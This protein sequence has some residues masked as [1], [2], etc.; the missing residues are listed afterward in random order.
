M[1]YYE[2]S[3]SHSNS[4]QVR[5]AELSILETMISTRWSSNVSLLLICERGKLETQSTTMLNC[6]SKYLKE[7]YERARNSEEITPC[8][9]SALINQYNNEC[10]FDVRQMSTSV[11][12]L[13][14]GSRNPLPLILYYPIHYA[15][16][17]QEWRLPLLYP[18]GLFFYEGRQK[19]RR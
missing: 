14:E 11:V 4:V 12:S 19:E 13:S 1:C 15:N 16:C 17:T 5:N 8:Q 7:M 18:M 9:I 2:V 3:Q 6:D 10:A